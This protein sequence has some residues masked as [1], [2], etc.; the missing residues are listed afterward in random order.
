MRVSVSVYQKLVSGHGL[1]RR[2]VRRKTTVYYFSR[3]LD[4]LFATVARK[5]CMTSMWTILTENVQEQM[6]NL[7]MLEKISTRLMNTI[8][9]TITLKVSVNKNNYLLLM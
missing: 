4:I 8:R 6:E 1:V 2:C 3:C 5:V 9:M 7:L